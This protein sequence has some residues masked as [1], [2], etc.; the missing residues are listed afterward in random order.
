MGFADDVGWSRLA[1]P[2]HHRWVADGTITRLQALQRDKDDADPKALACY[3]L[4]VHR[5]PQH[6]DQLLLRFVAGRPVS[7]S[8]TDFLAWC[9]DRLAQQGITALLL[10]WDN[11]S[12][13]TSELVRA[14]IHAHNRRVKQA[15]HGVRIVSCLLPSKSPWLNPIEPKWVHGKRAV[16]EPDRM[17]SAEEL[18]ARICAYYGCAREAHLVMPEK[19]A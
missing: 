13:H 3:G 6:A 5:R 1:Q 19:V 14:W 12:W 9:C 2:D 7:A 11:A 15:G 17:L 4:L 18:E 8:T 10:I 16:S